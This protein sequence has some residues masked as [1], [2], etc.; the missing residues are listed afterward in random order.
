MM[1]QLKYK[2]H[3]ITKNYKIHT[4]CFGKVKKVLNNIYKYKNT[5]KGLIITLQNEVQMAVQTKRSSK[6]AF[7]IDAMQEYL[8]FPKLGQQQI[9]RKNKKRSNTYNTF[10]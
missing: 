4:V 6:S 10:S 2:T 7:Q 3:Y 8:N 9:L 5:P 1:L